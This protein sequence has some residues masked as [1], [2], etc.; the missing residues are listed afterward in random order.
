MLNRYSHDGSDQM[1]THVYLSVRLSSVCPFVCLPS[2]PR[3]ILLIC[4]SPKALQAHQNP[5]WR[6]FF[7]FYIIKVGNTRSP[8]FSI[9]LNLKVITFFAQLFIWCSHEALRACQNSKKRMPFLGSLD[10]S[11]WFGIFLKT[12]R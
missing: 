2:L 9:K 5:H 7:Q 10:E 8:G 4:Y 3:E 1:N 12:W 11:L 6:F